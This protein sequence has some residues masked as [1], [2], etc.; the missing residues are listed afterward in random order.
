MSVRCSSPA[1]MKWILRTALP[2]HDLLYERSA[3][4]ISATEESD[5]KGN[6]CF[7]KDLHL[8]PRSSQNRM[9]DSY[10]SEAFRMKWCAMPVPPRH[11]LFGRQTCFCYT[12]DAMI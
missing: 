3:L 1:T 8:D 4:L 11:S 2:R 10:T 12:N 5:S 6:W 9:H 7:R